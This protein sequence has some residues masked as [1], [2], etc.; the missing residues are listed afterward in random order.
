MSVSLIDAAGV[1]GTGAT[2]PITTAAINT[3]GVKLLVVSVASYLGAGPDATYL[4][5]SQSNTWQVGKAQG[6]SD[7]LLWC[8]VFYCL[9]PTTN[10]S[11]TFTFTPSAGLGIG[12]Y[13]SM[14]VD[15][16]GAT[17]T[18]AFSTSVG[19]SAS[20]STIQAGSIG[21]ASDLVVEA[22]AYYANTGYSINSSFASPHERNYSAGNAMGLA[23]SWLQIGAAVNPTWTASGSNDQAAAAISFTETGGDTVSWLPSVF[24][25]SGPAFVV[26]RTGLTPPDTPV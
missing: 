7:P 2:T 20:A 15:A 26:A 11:H 4:T 16:Y 21:A 6:G 25:R 10:A 3:T 13:P 12:H 18:L 1:G 5:D 8:T 9:N 19:A 17:G 14:V 23:R 24:A 22:V